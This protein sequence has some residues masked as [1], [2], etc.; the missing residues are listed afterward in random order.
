VEEF[1]ENFCEYIGA[2]YACTINSATNAIFLLFLNRDIEVKIPSVIPP[3]VCNALL[4]S[5]NKINFVDNTEWV[6]NS[7]VLHDFGNYKI[8][9]SAQKVEKDQFKKEAQDNDIMFFSFY[10]T[11]PIG[12]CDGGI[13]VSNDQSKIEWLKEACLNGMSYAKDNWDRKIKFP[14]YKMYM[15]SIQAYIANENLKKLANKD[16]KLANIRDKYNYYFGLKNSSQHLYR[17]NLKNRKEF[18][19]TMKNNNYQTGI[20]YAA[21]HKSHVY[22]KYQLWLPKSEFD[23][24]TTL[25]IPFNEKLTTKEVQNIIKTVEKYADRY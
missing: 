15:N 8:I 7:Y 13:I 24:E 5:G 14:G 12:S 2:K 9:D 1:E 21:L 17:I 25:S 18:I 22:A 19:N 10:P 4:T 20:H 23:A 3:V 16:E 6:G 11:K